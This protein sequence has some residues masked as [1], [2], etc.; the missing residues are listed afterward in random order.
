MTNNFILTTQKQ[1]QTQFHKS[2]HWLQHNHT[3]L[4]FRKTKYIIFS[5]NQT[6]KKLQI[7]TFL[8]SEFNV[9]IPKEFN[10][11]KLNYINHSYYM[12]HL[13]LDFGENI[14]SKPVTQ[15]KYLGYHLTNNLKGHIQ[16]KMLKKTMNN[17]YFIMKQHMNKMPKLN[18]IHKRYY[19]EALF[20]SRIK[21]CTINLMNENITNLS[22][23]QTLYNKIIRY[24]SGLKRTTPITI[25]FILSNIF[26]FNI[27]IESQAIKLWIRS[28]FIHQSNA[29]YEIIDQRDGWF[30]KW[31][32]YIDNPLQTK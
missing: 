14:I 9:N 18:N 2:N 1:I 19:V 25:L 4:S 8:P 12:L 6:L 7:Y 3:E 17:G 13:E 27:T 22:P 23:L 26:P 11:S 5:N 21:Y 10:I 31:I 24:Y 29:L 20:H 16:I 28:L 15:V 32:K 30:S